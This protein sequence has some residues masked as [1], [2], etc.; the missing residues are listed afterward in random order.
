MKKT[1]KFLLVLLVIF[2]FSSA[3]S[4]AKDENWP[5]YMSRIHLFE[6]KNRVDTAIQVSKDAAGYYVSEEVKT[7]ILSGYE[8]QSD[9]LTATF[10]AGQL[11]AP[12]LVCNRSKLSSDL[13]DEI[14]RIAPEEIILAGGEQ[15]LAHSIEEELRA[16]GYSTIRLSGT[17]RID[18]ALELVKH[19]YKDKPLKE[20]FLVEYTALVDALAIGPVSAKTGTPILLTKNEGLAADVLDFIEDK[21][22]EKAIII[23]GEDTLGKEAFHEIERHIPQVKRISGSNRVRTSLAIAQRYF[24][25]AETAL[26]A[27]GW[28][29]IDALVGG[30]FGGLQNA[31][32][33]LTK[34]NML[35]D[36]ISDYLAKEIDKVY[37][38]G[39][40]NILNV[41]VYRLANWALW[42]K[43]G[44]KSHLI[45]K[46][47]TDFKRLPDHLPKGA[48]LIE[49]S[50][51]NYY[52]KFK[53]KK[54][55][56]SGMIFK[57]ISIAHPTLSKSRS[58]VTGEDKKGRYFVASMTP[59]DHTVRI[60]YFGGRPDISTKDFDHIRSELNKFYE[61]YGYGFEGLLG[62]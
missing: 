7:V 44:A 51:S 19:Y 61:A 14:E 41:N 5:D 43:Q 31:P 10:M 6:G 18:T 17:S 26:L 36:E 20:I 37:F 49:K 34:Q 62:L 46:P 30:Y 22:V 24:P 9:A 57:N 28:N 55:F 2:V 58:S 54:S 56:D 32:L 48:V 47:H 16:L 52:H 60:T 23:G 39:G 35:Y 1:I 50:A 38:L 53:Y 11:K 13:L 25:K 21:G 4:W 15:I 59:D 42:G 45:P 27:N 8:G 3:N 40:R 29:S 33:L 12:L